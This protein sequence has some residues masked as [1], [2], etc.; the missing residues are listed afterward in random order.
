VIPTA[1]SWGKDGH[2]IIVSWA[3][4]LMSGEGKK[5]LATHVVE[6]LGEAATWAD[7]PKAFA[8]YPESESHHFSHTPYQTCQEFQMDRD[9]GFPGSKGQCIVTGLA[10]AIGV[11]LD[12]TDTTEEGFEK[13]KDAVKFILHFMGDVHHPLHIGFSKDFGGNAIKLKGGKSLHEFWDNELIA[14]LISSIGGSKDWQEVVRKYRASFT[15]Q[16]V[17]GSR[18]AHDMEKVLSSSSEM[19]NYAA[20]IASETAIKSTCE[21]GYKNENGSWIQSGELLTSQFVKARTPIMILALSRAAVRLAQLIDGMALALEKQKPHEVPVTIPKEAKLFE[22]RISADPTFNRFEI[23]RID[24]ESLAESEVV[25]AESDRKEKTACG[26]K[27]KLQTKQ[28]SIS[29]KKK[30]TNQ[31]IKNKPYDDDKYFYDACAESDA[32]DRYKFEG[33]D[34]SLIQA[35]DCDGIDLITS[36]ENSKIRGYQP[37]SVIS[38]RVTLDRKGTKEPKMYFFD[39]SVFKSDVSTE[40]AI[41]CILKVSGVVVDGKSEIDNYWTRSSTGT[42]SVEKQS[43]LPAPTVVKPIDETS[44]E[45]KL[46]ILIDKEQEEVMSSHRRALMARRSAETEKRFKEWEKS[47]KSQDLTIVDMWKEVIDSQRSKIACYLCGSVIAIILEDTLKKLGS[48]VRFPM[49]SFV[50]DTTG[51]VY[52]VIIDPEIFEGI[53]VKPFFEILQ[54]IWDGS[55]EYSSSLLKY[56]PTWA[57]ELH[58]INVIFS[59]KEV[60]RIQNLRILHHHAYYG[61][62]GMFDVE[63]SLKGTQTEALHPPGWDAGSAAA[64]LHAQLLAEQAK[65]KRQEK[66]QRR[67]R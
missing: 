52:R 67:R 43:A 58:D 38:F 60:D 42:A 65:T 15:P 14:Q 5:F 23:L 28:K 21:F 18:T 57:D 25:T 35:I 47:K 37:L 34:L 26:N 64:R 45:K 55:D 16:Y 39:P 56:R 7:T 22:T 10:A 11:A 51:D 66:P 1:Y 36:N 63:W 59:G 53:N 32:K 19:I 29:G 30:Q 8:K 49:H 54:G 62:A 50:Q 24:I 17:A 6:D 2:K 33:I 12:T 20:W 13:R 4:E 27:Q 31:N 9:C 61:H 41:R 3:K 48:I 44:L 46:A 40:L